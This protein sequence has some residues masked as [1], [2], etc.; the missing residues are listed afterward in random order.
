M[1]IFSDTPADPNPDWARSL[2]RGAFHEIILVLRGALPPPVTDDPAD[3]ARRDRAAMAGVAAL[4]PENAA[5]G[6]LAAQFVAADAW[7][8]DCLRLAQEKRREPDIA[9]KCRAQAMG[10]M[11]EGKSALRMLLRL[12]AV[13]QKMAADEEAAS[14]AAWAEH[15]AAGMMAEALAAEA[16]APGAVDEPRRAASAEGSVVRRAPAKV[17]ADAGF[18]AGVGKFRVV[19]E[20]VAISRGARSETAARFRPSVRTAPRRPG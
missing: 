11:R 3:E 17:G 6:R 5:E 9:R 4:R 20:N 15:G 10:M 13:R 1:D 19:S 18:E 14:R 12:Q 7:A 2:P 16:V 8:M